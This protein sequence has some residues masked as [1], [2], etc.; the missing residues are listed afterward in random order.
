MSLPEQPVAITQAITKT[1]TYRI[2]KGIGQEPL[3]IDFRENSIRKEGGTQASKD[4]ISIKILN[5]R[6]DRTTTVA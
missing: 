5:T 6:Q 1:L 3:L 4:L 2:R